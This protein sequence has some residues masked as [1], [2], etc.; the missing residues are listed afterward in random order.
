M[1]TA[2]VHV[3]DA[4]RILQ[5]ARSPGIALLMVL[6]LYVCMCRAVCVCVR[7]VSGGVQREPV[8]PCGPRAVYISELPAL[9]SMGPGTPWGVGGTPYTCAETSLPEGL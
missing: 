1:R 8:R 7:V 6:L 2:S 4:G 5:E 9:P 3:P